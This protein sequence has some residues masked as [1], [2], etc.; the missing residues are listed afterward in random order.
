M[1][2]FFTLA[3]MLLAGAAR[4]DDDSK[5]PAWL[6]GT[7][8]TTDLDRKVDGWFV[9]ALPI[10]AFDPNKGLE[11]GAAG[12]LT[13]D[14][15]RKDPLFAYS[16]YRHRFYAQFLAST[17]GFIQPQLTYE[18][19]YVGDTPFRLRVVLEYDRNTSANYFGNGETTLKN[20]NYGGQSF[21]TYDDAVSALGNH[22][23]HYGYDKPVG[24]VKIERGFF[25]GR[26]R[27]Q[28]GVTVQHTSITRQDSQA[29]VWL[30]GQAPAP[31]GS[32][33]TKLGMDCLS[34]AATGCNGGWNNLV[35]LGI[36]YDTRDYEPDPR[37]GVFIDATGQ[38]SARAF[39]SAADYGR[40]TMAA[41]LYVSPF[42]KLADLVLAG[43]ALYSIQSADVPFYAMDTL[44]MAAGVDDWTDQTG[45][46]GERTLRGYHDDRFVGHV[47][48]AVNAEVRWTFT[49]FDLLRQ[50]FS[51][52]VAPLFDAGRVFDRV[53][54]SFKDWRYSAGGGLRVGW[55]RSSIIIFDFAMSP[56]DR[57][58]ED[59]YVDYGMPF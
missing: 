29:A 21:D 20:L 40:F 24:E 19:I 32:P 10:V 37:S 52:Q 27:A 30:D 7:R 42:P 12:H 36:A 16:P 13:L 58:P 15:S 11:L 53:D 14:G 28:A 44:G 22:Y 9:D 18:G 31:P 51:L 41:R 3:I 39:G 45:L 17:G 6:A 48:T 4:A 54:F 38:L 57:T 56:E 59:F 1:R 23:Y 55:N 5:L 34:G 47:A 2:A 25:G 50:H 26:L 8:K 49:R 35:K 43:R 33:T 46:G